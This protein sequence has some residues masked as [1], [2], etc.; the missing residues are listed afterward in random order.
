LSNIYWG[1]VNGFRGLK[2]TEVEQRNYYE[3][4]GLDRGASEDE[5]RNA[6]KE[7]ARIF[8]PDSNFFADIIE[9]RVGEQADTFKR[10]TEAYQVL[11]NS[12]K[13]AE[14]DKTLPPVLKQW[15]EESESKIEHPVKQQSERPRAHTF[16]NITPIYDKALKT[17]AFGNARHNTAEHLRAVKQVPSAYQLFNTKRS[18]REKILNLLKLKP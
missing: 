5:I 14:Y 3:L 13:R 9:D 12:N 6:Y 4:L 18:L 16:S 10:V 15:V 17:K 2:V 11:V 1:I 8:H 7:L